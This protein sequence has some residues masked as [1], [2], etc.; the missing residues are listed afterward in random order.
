MAIS[1]PFKNSIMIR[2]S[3]LSGSIHFISIFER[4]KKTF[5]SQ[6]C[7]WLQIHLQHRVS[8]FELFLLKKILQTLRFYWLWLN[9]QEPCFTVNQCD[10][11]LGL[12]SWFRPSWN[13][14]TRPSKCQTNLF[15]YVYQSLRRTNLKPFLMAFKTS[16]A[17][18][19]DKV[20]LFHISDMIGWELK[21]CILHGI[22]FFMQSL[23]IFWR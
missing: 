6:T 12:E 20:F 18:K 23:E 13:L 2:G 8:F 5:L 21:F 15:R 3:L 17:G 16:K 22:F 14:Q 7:H 4:C 11:D 1:S 19:T 9:V 10:C